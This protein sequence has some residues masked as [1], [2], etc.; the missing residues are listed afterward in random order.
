MKKLYA[1]I[2]FYL[3]FYITIYTFGCL[4]QDQTKP[5]TQEVI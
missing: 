3:F 5:T 2:S 4:L 1:N